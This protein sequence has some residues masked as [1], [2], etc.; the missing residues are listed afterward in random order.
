MGDAYLD[1]RAAGEMVKQERTDR[2]ANRHEAV[3]ALMAAGYA[4]LMVSEEARHYRIRLARNGWFDWWPSTDR[5]AQS[6]RPGGRR[7]KRGMGLAGL[8]A[9]LNAEAGA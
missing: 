6:M 8:L 2:W 4:P 3:N 7:G 1:L 9:A 5:W